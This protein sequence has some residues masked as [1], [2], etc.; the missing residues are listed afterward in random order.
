MRFVLKFTNIILFLNYLDEPIPKLFY[1]SHTNLTFL[2]VV[3]NVI[4]SILLVQ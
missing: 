4:S 1:V 2:K 3:A